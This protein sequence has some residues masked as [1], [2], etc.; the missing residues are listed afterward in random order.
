KSLRWCSAATALGIAGLL[1][2]LG[3]QAAAQTFSRPITVIDGYPAGNTV[4]VLY[5]LMAPDVSKT[6]GQTIISDNRPGAS[7]R[8]GLQVLMKARGDVHMLTTVN[9]ANI[10]TLPLIDQTFKIEPGKDYTPVVSTHSNP[11]V[12][13]TNPMTGFRDIKGMV[14][15][16]KA[17]P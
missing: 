17:N 16:E 11:F 6:L 4:D 7:G 2:A 8:L 1:A 3:T 12:L 14:A 9:P 13:T 5:R 10:V 15:W